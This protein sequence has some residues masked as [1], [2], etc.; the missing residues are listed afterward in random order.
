MKNLKI[1]TRLS[2]AFALLVAMLLTLALT[3]LVQLSSLRNE[4]ENITGNWLP[5]VE[6]V[7]ALEAHS[8]DLRLTILA[9][10]LSTDDSAKASIDKQISDQRAKLAEMRSSYEKLI[11]S[12]AEKKLYEDYLANWSKYVQINDKALALSR[13]NDSAAAAALM[14]QESRPM[15]LAIKE[16]LDTLIKINHQGAM[17]ASESAS[18]TGLVRIFVCEA[19]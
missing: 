5:S 17:E 9:H 18:Q 14:S 8:A 15:Y 6:A 13:S 11:S 3:S 19:H 2:G 10:V 12:P 16:Q 4:T 1:S 7:N